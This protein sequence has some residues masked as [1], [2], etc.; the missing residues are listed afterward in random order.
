MIILS[1][2][3][4][5]TSPEGFVDLLVYSLDGTLISVIP[6]SDHGLSSTAGG[7]P[8]LSADGPTLYARLFE[9]PWLPVAAFAM[10]PLL[11]LIRVHGD[12]LEMP[13]DGK[14]NALPQWQAET[15]LLW[16]SSFVHGHCF[17]GPD[18]AGALY[19]YRLVPL[20]GI[21]CWTTH[22]GKQR[23]TWFAIRHLWE[24]YSG[25]QNTHTPRICG[26]IPLVPGTSSPL[27]LRLQYSNPQGTQHCASIIIHRVLWC[28]TGVATMIVISS[29]TL[30][31][32]ERLFI[33]R[34]L[35]TKPRCT[36]SKSM[37]A[38]YRVC[39]RRWVSVWSNVHFFSTSRNLL[40][41]RLSGM[42]HGPLSRPNRVVSISSNLGSMGRNGCSFWPMVGR[43]IHWSL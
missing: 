24:N 16:N 5:V 15:H 40:T 28:G 11:E 2:H 18:R 38:N 19:P 39:M 6:V 22:F 21:F 10:P 4:A 42:G 8:F 43:L 36:I 1:A 37:P 13:S 27:T 32:V 33:A 34:T 9:T 7:L 30:R 17:A 26:R 12:S 25:Q 29:G 23:D 3:D 35:Q 20:G 31:M 41:S 14:E